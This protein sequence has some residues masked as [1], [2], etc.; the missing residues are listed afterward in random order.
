MIKTHSLK[1][2]LNDP[3]RDE[4]LAD[5]GR[6]ALRMAYQ[7]ILGWPRPEMPYE[8]ISLGNQPGADLHHEQ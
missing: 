7:L 8:K 2:S 5:P 3:S 6:S 1:I 4:K